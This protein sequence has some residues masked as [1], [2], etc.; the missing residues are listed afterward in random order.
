M[1][2][3]NIAEARVNAQIFE[4]VHGDKI[5]ED[6]DFKRFK[7]EDK[8][9]DY[10]LSQFAAYVAENPEDLVKKNKATKL[11]A[12]HAIQAILSSAGV[13]YT[14]DNQEV[15]G[16]SKVEEQ[17]SRRAELVQDA[18]WGDLEG[19]SALFA[20]EKAT[21]AF[22]EGH[23]GAESGFTPDF[24]PPEDVK[25]RQ[26]CSMAKSF[27]FDSVTEFALLVEQMTQQERRDALDSFYK[28]RVMELLEEELKKDKNA[29]EKKVGILK[30]EAGVSEDLEFEAEDYKK[31]VK[32]EFDFKGQAFP[33][34]RAESEH[35]AS[36]VKSESRGGQPA[37][38]KEV[39]MAPELVPETRPIS[40]L[41]VFDDGDDDDVF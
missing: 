7:Q 26:F 1:N 34:G 36:G 37:L 14:H 11:Q 23:D 22:I 13:R 41:F 40:S 27:G 19:Q 20:E 38:K 15:I 18:D 28:R 3:T 16:S 33:S 29:D 21:D 9:D 30:A 35:T 32:I 4:D 24:K 39:N 2:Q 6:D 12:D 17:L 25:Q 10:G 8:D 5:E 31:D